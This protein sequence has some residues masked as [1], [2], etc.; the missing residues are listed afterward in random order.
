MAFAG[1]LKYI[2][3]KVPRSREFPAPSIMRTTYVS[4]RAGMPC[5]LG[6]SMSEHAGSDVL[7][8]SRARGVSDENCIPGADEDEKSKAHRRAKLFSVTP[9]FGTYKLTSVNFWNSI[10][11]TRPSRWCSS[12]GPSAHGGNHSIEFVKHAAGVSLCKGMQ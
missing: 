5:A 4:S 2:L 12:D 10:A 1:K 9:L 3:T 6:T 11:I 7:S 8:L